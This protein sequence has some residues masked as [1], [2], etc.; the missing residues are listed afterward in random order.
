MPYRQV[1]RIFSHLFA[2][3]RVHD[4]VFPRT[5]ESRF[6]RTNMAI[7]LVRPRIA[8]LALFGRD[9]S[10][11]RDRFGFA[12]VASSPTE[13]RPNAGSG[14]CTHIERKKFRH[15]LLA[16]AGGGGFSGHSL[17]PQPI[18]LQ[19]DETMRKLYGEFGL[20]AHPLFPGPSRIA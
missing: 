12:R 4:H 9:F 17:W 10:V 7:D 18:L 13:Q 1:D 8:P 11:L 16:G 19:K 5:I 15:W 14:L 20:Q 6:L 3:L 2:P